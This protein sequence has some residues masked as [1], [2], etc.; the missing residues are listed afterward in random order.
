MPRE[1]DDVGC[2]LPELGDYLEKLKKM[3]DKEDE[4]DGKGMFDSRRSDV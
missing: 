4:S 1:N 3:E 2:G